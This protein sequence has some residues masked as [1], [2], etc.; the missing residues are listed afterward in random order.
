MSEQGIPPL[1]LH[2][3]KAVPNF[4]DALN[5]LIVGHLAGRDV[6]H[7]APKNADMFAIGSLLQ[8]VKRNFEDPRAGA[9]PVIWGTGLLHS[10]Q[11]KGFLKNVD[12]ALM[13]GPVTAALLGIEDSVF[14]DPG[15]LVNEVLP[16]DGIGNDQIGVVPHHSLLDDTD[17][18]AFVASDPAYVLIDPRRDTREVCQL[19]ASCAHILASSLHGL[20]VADAYGVS[21]TWI[22]PKGQSHLKYLDYAA[23][24]GRGDMRVPVALDEVDPRAKSRLPYQDGIAACRAALHTTFPTQFRGAA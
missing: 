21:N 9:A 17:V 10:V 16:F 23:S 1:R 2:W 13:R 15:L 6:V 22:H 7:A 8:V 18:L 24:V 5:P 4:G 20:I 14:G 11:A 3:W 12:I 19:I